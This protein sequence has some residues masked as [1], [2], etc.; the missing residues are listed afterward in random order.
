[1]SQSK[2]Q[3]GALIGVLVV[4]VIIAFLYLGSLY[5]GEKSEENNPQNP[6]G[7][8]EEAEN[9]VEEANRQTGEKNKI[10]GEEKQAEKAEEKETEEEA[11]GTEEE[12]SSAVESWRTL[13]SEQ[14]GISIDYPG[15]WYYNIN[16]EEAEELGYDLIVGFASS[17]RIWEMDLPYPIEFVVAGPDTEIKGAYTKELEVRDN[18]KHILRTENREYEKI[19]DQMTESFKIINN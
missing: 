5:F 4:I 8:L 19:I 10:I 6:V 3:G 9:T 18:K 14:I 2:T 1:M 7:D 17:S 12:Q 15:G 13:E 16:H 11:E